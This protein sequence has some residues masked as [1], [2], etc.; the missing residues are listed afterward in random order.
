M[1]YLL[2][3]AALLAFAPSAFAADCYITEYR[4]VVE[5]ARGEHVPVAS[6][7]VT[8]QRVTY[9]TSTQS[10]AFN[11][12]TKFVRVVCTAAAHFTFAANPTAT[13]NHPYIP[14]NA[15]EYFGVT[16]GQE[17]AFYDGTS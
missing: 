5:V 3:I 9:T 16:A 10:S 17:V 14:S 7:I 11:A 13:A 1:K 8:T 12:A 4:D 2:V 6:S 15:A